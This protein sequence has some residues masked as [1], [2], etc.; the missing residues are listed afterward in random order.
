MTYSADQL[1]EMGF[2]VP[3]DYRPHSWSYS[4]AIRQCSNCRSKE[5]YWD[6]EEYPFDP[7]AA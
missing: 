7:C 3:E 2:E 4:G 1:A 5:A 6:D